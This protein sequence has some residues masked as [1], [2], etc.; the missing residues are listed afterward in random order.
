MP[1]PPTSNWT[2]NPWIGGWR[3]TWQLTRRKEWRGRVS[4][5][6][7]SLDRR[8][9]CQSGDRRAKD[10]FRFSHKINDHSRCLSEFQS[11]Q[12]VHSPKRKFWLSFGSSCLCF[13]FSKHK[14][15]TQ[16]LCF[17]TNCKKTQTLC[18][19]LCFYLGISQT[20]TQ[21]FWFVFWGQQK[22]QTLCLCFVFSKHKHKTRNTN[23]VNWGHCNHFP[24]SWSADGERNNCPIK[25]ETSEY[26]FL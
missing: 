5:R 9:S 17:F 10:S 25:T 6:E 19:C 15:Q 16:T 23:F 1:W 22:K 26:W 7:S 24:N 8:V 4:V 2:I 21:T 11:T 18:L 13:V 14:L 20:Q 3:L 12:N